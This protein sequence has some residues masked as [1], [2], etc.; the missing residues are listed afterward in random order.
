MKRSS[1]ILV[2]VALVVSWSC[3]GSSSSSVAPSATVL[4][5]A[6]NGSTD[7]TSIGKT[8]QLTATATFSDGATQDVSATAA[9][10]ALSVGATVT[11]G[12]LVTAVTSGTVTIIATYQ[13]KSGLAVVRISPTTPSRS[14]MSATIDGASWVAISVSVTKIGANSAFPSGRLN[15]LGTNS[16]TGQYVEVVVTIPAVVGTY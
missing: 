15:I 10:Q 9:W 1:L 13:G 5:V 8:I 7:F 14:S 16:F 2:L 3:G 6:V 11:S 4:S 12:G